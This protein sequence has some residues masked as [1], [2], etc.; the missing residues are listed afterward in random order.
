MSY[1][2]FQVQRKDNNRF[3]TIAIC[4]DSPGELTTMLRCLERAGYDIMSMRVLRH[5]SGKKLALV[6]S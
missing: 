3:D 4:A 5:R 2:K 1:I 6:A